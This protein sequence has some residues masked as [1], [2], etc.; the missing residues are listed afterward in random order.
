MEVLYL[1]YIGCPGKESL[2]SDSIFLADSNSPK[3]QLQTYES[4]VNFVSFPHETM[5]KYYK[6]YFLKFN[7]CIAIVYTFTLLALLNYRL[8]S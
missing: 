7:G 4:S 3:I 6:P 2:K 5:Q 8:H 1:L